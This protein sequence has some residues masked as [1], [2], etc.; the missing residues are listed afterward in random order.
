MGK[1]L[2]L[3]NGHGED[4]SASYIG[5]H[6]ISLGHEVEALP[7]VGVGKFYSY[8]NIRIIL[9][10][11]NFSTGGIGYTSLKGRLTELLE[12][13]IIYLFKRIIKLLKNASKYD[14]IV[15]IGDV[16]PV[17]LSWISQQK[18]VTYL[19]A[20]SSHYEG[21]LRLP[22]P[23]KRCLKSQNS[24]LIMG[25]DMLTAND[26]SKQLN[27]EVY[28][29]GNAFMEPLNEYKILK[30]YKYRICLLPGSRQPELS[31]NLL[32]MLKMIKNLPN[33]LFK[34][35]EIKL[36]MVLVKSLSDIQLSNLVSQ[37]GWSIRHDSLKGILK[38]INK[39]FLISVHRNSFASVIHSSDIVISMAGTAAEQAVGLSKPVLQLVGEGPQFTNSF[40]EAQ[41][42]LLGPT[43]FCAQGKQGEKETLEETAKMAIHLLKEIRTNKIF[44][45]ECK[46]QAL[47]RIGLANGAS[48]IAK[49]ISDLI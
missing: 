6:L 5:K 35:E 32:L 43:V 10:G 23:C 4:L 29:L 33:E 22:W 44:Q 27:R 49:K 14:L 3:S 30:K 39:D 2:L 7:L 26:L 18:N 15:S 24:L 13:Q 20:Y 21:R 19:V 47:L 16:L 17:F 36:E 42:R 37:R 1:I 45:E 48:K 8:Q 31:R 28:F 38:I 11:K 46:Q 40:A 12:G 25:R 41:R 9:D 34:K